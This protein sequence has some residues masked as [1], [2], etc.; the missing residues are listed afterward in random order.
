MLVM[1]H[2]G[3]TPSHQWPDIADEDCAAELKTTCR[4]CRQSAYVHA[5]PEWV[6]EAKRRYR[7]KWPAAWFGENG[8][9]VDDVDRGIC[10][11]CLDLMGL[12]KWSPN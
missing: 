9:R 1:V 12:V 5:S 10:P 4:T 6:N 11:G 2:D 3:H 7:D 8:W